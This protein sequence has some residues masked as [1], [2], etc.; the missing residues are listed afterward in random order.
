MN[1]TRGQLLQLNSITRSNFTKT[2]VT[3]LENRGVIGAESAYLNEEEEEE[4][5]PRKGR[6]LR[7]ER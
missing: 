5:V 3:A 6:D 2:S 7:Q 4:S 1:A